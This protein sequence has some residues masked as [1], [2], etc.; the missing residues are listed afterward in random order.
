MHSIGR[1]ERFQPVLTS[2]RR[3]FPGTLLLAQVFSAY[4]ASVRAIPF[5]RRIRPAT[6]I[7]R[8]LA[9]CSAWTRGSL[10]WSSASAT[11]TANTFPYSW[12]GPW[13]H[14]PSA[15]LMLEIHRGRG[16]AGADPRQQPGRG[17]AGEGHQPDRPGIAAA[18]HHLCAR[19][20]RGR[21]AAGRG[22]GA[23]HR[24]HRGRRV[25]DRRRSSGSG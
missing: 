3:L 24:P 17:A 23:H 10:R 19:D 18:P 20:G 21:T 6:Q 5:P 8:P 25:R 7:A 12:L 1:M 2:A 13:K 15:G 14:N 22:G 4:K 11:A 16:D 9:I